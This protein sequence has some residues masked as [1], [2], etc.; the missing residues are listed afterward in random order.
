[1]GVSRDTFYRIREAKE[2]G[3]DA[4]LHKDRRRPNIKN[5]VDDAIETAVLAYAIENRPPDRCGYQTSCAS[6]AF[7]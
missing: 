4:L 1:M 5:R 3:M 7:L 6:A 2:S